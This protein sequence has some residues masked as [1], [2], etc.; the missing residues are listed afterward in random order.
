[1]T[2]RTATQ[3]DR[4]AICRVHKAAFSENER[5]M[6]SELA[7]KL[8]V[9]ETAPKTISL[10]AELEGGIVG[11]VALSPVSIEN[12]KSFLGFIL[13]PLGVAPAY[14]NRRIGTT[15]IES[16]LQRVSS[17]GANILFVYGDPN[18][19]GKFGFSVEAAERYNPPYKLQYPSGWQAITLNAY[20]ARKTSA[21]IVVVPS[22]RNSAL[23]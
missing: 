16:G 6:V 17:V 14:Q 3:L 9:E 15:L 18:Y 10:V 13:A 4:D 5:E 7:I 2:V 21:D 1:M 12:E 23:W 20:A 19:Y 8:L 11:H 22:L